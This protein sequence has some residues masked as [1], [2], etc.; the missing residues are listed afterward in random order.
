MLT[1]EEARALIAAAQ[2]EAERVGKPI[3]ACVVDAGGFIISVDRM[4]GAR[5]LTPSI[6]HAKAYTG[7]I[8][9]RPASMLKGWA[10]GQPGF[11]AQVS[12]MGHQPIVYAEGGI[13][14]KRDGHLLGGLGVAGGLGHED[15]EIAV[16]A[17]A[18]LGYDTNFAEWNALRPGRKG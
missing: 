15:E 1:L 5:P 6:A 8:M 13:T 9:E 11:F 10:E 3:T 7:A 16:N 17:L 2:K 4:A 14:I 18:A 12:R